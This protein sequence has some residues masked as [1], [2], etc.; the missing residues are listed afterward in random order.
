MAVFRSQEY[1]MDFKTLNEFIDSLTEIKDMC[2]NGDKSIEFVKDG[3]VID[4]K[5]LL[6]TVIDELPD[7]AKEEGLELG[8]TTIHFDPVED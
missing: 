3:Y 8:T 5:K 1:V 6:V 7:E 2:N 4:L